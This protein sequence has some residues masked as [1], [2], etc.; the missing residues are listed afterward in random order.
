[1]KRIL[2]TVKPVLIMLLVLCTLLS[3]CVTDTPIDNGT[4]GSD[5]THEHTTTQPPENNEGNNDQPEGPI[6]CTHAT[7]T[8]VGAVAA[9][10]A[11]EGYT[12][13]TVCS[14]CTEVISQGTSIAKLEHTWNNGETTK[15]PTCISTGVK[16]ITCTACG[17]TKTETLDT[18]AHNDLYHDRLDGT[19]SHTCS[20][21][22]LSENKEHTKIEESAQFYAA[23]CLEPAYTEYTCADC[24]G[25][26]KV[27]SDKAEDKATGHSFGTWTITDS[28]CLSTGL[29]TRSCTN[30]GC[31]EH[32]EIVIEIDA[33]KHEWLESGRTAATCSTDGSVTYTCTHCQDTK[34]STLTATGV[35]SYYTLTP[36]GDGWTTQ[37]CHNCTHEISSFNAADVVVAEVKADK[38]PDDQNFGVTTEK[39]TI[40]FP[41]E[42]VSQLKG[43]GN[44]ATDISIG[45]EVVQD[46]ENLLAN[47]SN[48]SEAQKE[49]L[50]D[51][52][53]FDFSVKIDDQKLEQNFAEPVT[54][55]MPYTLKE[56]ENPDGIIIWYVADDGT[57]DEIE[58]VYNADTQTVTFSAEHF[59]FYAV[60]YKETQEMQC[61]RGHHD[62]QPT[63]EVVTATCETFGYTVYKCVCGAKML[64]EIVEKYEHSYGSLIKAQPTCEEGGWDH[65]ICSK[66]QNVLNVKYV[67]ALGHTLDKAATC[68]EPSTCTT[69]NKVVKPALGHAWT[70]WTTILEPTEVNSGLRRRYC[71]TCGEKEEVRLAATGN[72]QALTFESYEELFGAILAET[73]NFGNGKINVSYIMNGVTY[74]FD[75]KVNETD[76]AYTILIDLIMSAVMEGQSVSQTYSAL[77]RNGVLAYVSETESGK[78]VSATDLE[79]LIGGP[80][81]IFWDYMEQ[82]FE[83]LDPTVAMAL[84]EVKAMLDEY[85]ALYGADIDEVLAAMGSTFTYA[86]LTT[87][88]DSFETV[89]A[90]AALK[91]GYQSSLGMHEGVEIPT[92]NDFVN[93]ISAFMTKNEGDGRVDYEWN[94]QPLIDSL[95]AVVAYFSELCGMP[96]SEAFYALFGED[97]VKVNSTLIN[98]DECVTYVRTNLPGTTTVKNAVDWLIT[99]LEET[100][101]CTI[102]DVYALIDAFAYEMTGEEFDT[103]AFVAENGSVTLDMFVQAM[104]EDEEATLD[105]LYQALDE[106]L[107]ETLFG[108]VTVP[109]DG[110]EIALGELAEMAAYY[111]S[112]FNVTLD[113]SFAVDAQGNLIE[114][115]LDHKLSVIG[116]GEN[117]ETLT[118]EIEQMTML[119]K[120]DDS[121]TVDVPAIMQ[122]VVSNRVTA[123]YDQ[124]G[125]LIISGLD[126]SFTYEFSIKGYSDFEIAELLKRDDTMSTQLGCDVYVTDKAFWSQEQQVNNNSIVEINGKYYEAT[127]QWFSG[128]DVVVS[129]VAWADMMSDPSLIMPGAD[130]EPIGYYMEYPVYDTVI[131]YAYQG[132]EGWMLITECDWNYEWREDPATGKGKEY[133]IFSVWQETALTT[134]LENAYIGSIRDYNYKATVNGEERYL[135]TMT[136]MVDEK[137]SFNLYCYVQDD[138]IIVAQTKWVDGRSVYKLGNEI[139]V[140]PEHDRKSTWESMITYVDANGA[141]ISAR[142]TFLSLY[143]K[144]PTYYVK[145]A[146]GVYVSVNNLC[147]D[148]TVDGLTQITLPDGNV[149][150]V[151]G[152]VVEKNNNGGM[153][154]NMGGSVVVRPDGSFD[155]IEKAAVMNGTVVE[156]IP[157]D[158]IVSGGIVSGGTAVQNGRTLTYGYVKVADG[159]YVQVRCYVNGETV[160]EVTYRDEASDRWM[161]FDEI[162]DLGQYMTKNSDGTYTV[163]A[164]LLAKLKAQCTEEGDAYAI[165]VIGVK[166]ENGTTYAVTATVGTYMIPETLQMGGMSGSDVESKPWVDWDE[167]FSGNYGGDGGYGELYTPQLNAD[168]SL[169]LIFRNGAKLDVEIE[170]GK[171]LIAD[172]FLIYNAEESQKTGL[173]IYDCVEEYE[174]GMSLIYKDGKYYYWST[175]Y[176]YDMTVAN[177]L[178]SLIANGWYISEMTYRYDLQLDETTIV[179]VYDAYVRFQRDTGYNFGISSVH[180]FF[181]V[182]DGELYA[183]K[184]TEE[185]GD[186]MLRCEEI[187]KASEYFASL[188]LEDSEGYEYSTVYVNGVAT[189]IYRATVTLFE[190]NANGEPLSPTQAKVREITVYYMLVN[191]QKQYLTVMER[192][193]GLY[194]ILGNEA[195]VNVSEYE[196]ITYS[197]SNYLNGTFTWAHFYQ[198]YTETTHFVKLAGKCYRL[199]SYEMNRF[200]EE[201]FKDSFTEKLFCYRVEIGGEW[202]YYEICEFGKD[203]SGNEVPIL[204]N[205]MTVTVVGEEKTE[206]IGKTADGLTVEAVTVR[207]FNPDEVVV[208]ENN[209]GT[210]LYARPAY[211]DYCL[212]GQD[213]YYV[214]AYMVMNETTGVEE[215]VCELARAYVDDDILADMGAFDK[216]FTVDGN[217]LTISADIFELIND[218]N[219]YDFYIE[220]D[221]GD[222]WVTLDYFDLIELFN[223][224]EDDGKDDDN[225]GD[226]DKWGDVTD[227][228]DTWVDVNGNGMFDEEDEWKDLNGNGVFDGKVP[229]AGN[230]EPGKDEGEI[231]EPEKP[232]DGREDVNG[233]GNDDWGDADKENNEVII[234]NEGKEDV[235]TDG[236]VTDK[237]DVTDETTETEKDEVN[238]DGTV[239]EKEDVKEEI[240]E[241]EKKTA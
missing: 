206:V 132:N 85:G 109:I 214:R 108:E 201:S 65:Q 142:V 176:G 241:S 134:A 143:K 228:T 105:M 87:V 167:L 189:K 200:S 147:D 190:T 91:L 146:N 28:T 158:G 102:D 56:G 68:T 50:N 235:N 75:M 138:A 30:P 89:Y 59:S 215:L 112:M 135:S 24:H 208:T 226:D 34:S 79:T 15:N 173:Q 42:V 218:E 163:S 128:Q 174:T 116:K 166:T 114:V 64:D 203:A 86:D 191:G 32:E 188:V 169:T 192:L 40:E 21:C 37:R 221:C 57:I 237:E 9:T 17:D 164:E 72:I 123:A 222:D 53:I 47:A 94:V 182:I 171:N 157:S 183:L 140:L 120:I 96:I 46:K 154:G 97:L 211:G 168:G 156:G 225:W 49:R 8:L 159:L 239:T 186:G 145:A 76:G 77:Y 66:C 217:N 115:N 7:T 36:L 60:A 2:H 137:T 41:K 74:T 234:P 233:E 131:G 11:Q 149:M 153:G 155:H 38:I 103:A 33:N 151:H 139:T 10:C 81:D 220:I 111:L 20:T 100:D 73:L 194:L 12:G 71:L 55:T 126:G 150:Y 35:H 70:E 184:Q 25:V 39:A 162:Y 54:V 205:E 124:N 231:V 95:N 216:Y 240:T 238:A 177:S 29:K 223:I 26:Y 44:T 5:G 232:D 198:T 197:D 78:I 161:A 110:E 160:E 14:A 67:A 84:E 199:D 82:T 209:D 195:T 113:F 104:V 4:T 212:K 165:D 185:L 136:V 90:Y 121:V 45:A 181:A 107:S 3:S 224:Q 202:K 179:P 127:Y 83:L 69:C 118:Q 210:V 229:G 178:E 23:T 175:A 172:D 119:F 204:S 61:R 22:T 101:V 63:A 144:L 180:V 125:N 99:L 16:T 152:S 227:E 117:G 31:S 6:A 92:K 93:V 62:Y 80:F 207:Y 43:D 19:H 187:V 170:A 129:T 48:L 236:T 51:V 196:D 148:V 230:N 27:Y 219:R 18:V 141:E 98:W 58:A 130:A 193:D 133:R 1:M 13:D 88:L 122:P 52:E 213:G 106:M